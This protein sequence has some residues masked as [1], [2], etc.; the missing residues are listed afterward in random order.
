MKKLFIIDGS[1]FLYR[2]YYAFPE[3]LNDKWENYNVVYGFFR[4]MLKIFLDKPEYFVIA[5]DA[6][7][8]THRHQIYPEYKA[9]RTKAPDDFK[10][11]IPV[12]QKIVEELKIPSLVIPWYEADDL[13]SACVKNYKNNEEIVSY[14]YSSDKDLKQLLDENNNVFIYDPMKGIRTTTKEFLQEFMFEPKYILDYLSLV[15]DSADNIKG[16]PWIGS[17]WASDLI[18]KYQTI[19]NIYENIDDIGGNIQKKLFEGKESAFYSKKL[20]ELEKVPELDNLS[21]DNLKLNI[22]FTEYNKILMDQNWL[23]GLNK[24]LWELK[25]KYYTPQQDSLF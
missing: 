18:K 10:Q 6:P 3:M 22:D 14:V 5:W 9:N 19:E 8:K 21:L 23:K 1:G 4:M 15:W 12:I 20:I 16:V 7:T 25:N 13:I 17:K 11:Q 24:I 2:A